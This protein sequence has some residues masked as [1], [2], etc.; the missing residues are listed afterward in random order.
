MP[1]GAPFMKF[2]RAHPLFLCAAALLILIGWTG[3]HKFEYALGVAMALL[4]IIIFDLES[5]HAR[6][7]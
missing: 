2:A 7:D 4:S 3:I 1:K 5:Q 6:A